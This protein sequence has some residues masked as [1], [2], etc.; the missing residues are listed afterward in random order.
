MIIL[1]LWSYIFNYNSIVNGKNV[2]NVLYF[3]NPEVQYIFYIHFY[4]FAS[5]FLNP[6]EIGERNVVSEQFL[7]FILCFVVIIDE[8]IFFLISFTKILIS[9]V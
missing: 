7:D 1:Q 9:F 5:F 6:R 2:R 4:R 8:I 3:L